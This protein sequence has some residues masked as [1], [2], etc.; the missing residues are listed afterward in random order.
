MTIEERIRNEIRT[1]HYSLKTEK[2]YVRW[3]KRFVRHHQLRHPEQMGRQEI[4]EFL[5]HLAVDGRVAAS[6]QNQALAAL[7]FLY[8]QVLGMEIG[9]VEGFAYAKRGKRLPVV[10]NKADTVAVLEN[11][12][13]SPQD[14]VAHLLYGCGMRLSEALRLRIKDVD[15]G[16]GV[17]IVHDG[18]GQ[19]DRSTV[20]PRGL[21]EWMTDQMVIA[22]KFHEID[23]QRKRPGVQV[24]YALERK[25]PTIGEDWGWFWV[26]P[27]ENESVDPVSGVQRRHHIH[28]STVQK[29]VRS[30]SRVA[31]VVQRVTPHVFRHC[32]A[33]HL[34]EDGYDIRTVQELLGHKDVKTTMVY[35]HVMRPGGVAGVVS[36]LDN[37]REKGVIRGE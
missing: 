24:P 22:R 6:T 36:P 4:G 23:R 27:A 32:F 18:K 34:L 13:G 7:L 15:F 8:R 5:T 29:A 19:K 11:V 35:T 3:Y 21:C 25:K 1:R 9:Y 30:A 10:L 14:L 2:A 33:T 26:F 31:G 28:E 37:V 12:A 20:L 16:R 17:V